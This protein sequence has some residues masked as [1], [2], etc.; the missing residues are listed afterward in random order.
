MAWVLAVDHSIDDSHGLQPMP[1]RIHPLW[2]TPQRTALS[3][4]GQLFAVRESAAV[5]FK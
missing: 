3:T 4:C 1:R 5:A 2:L